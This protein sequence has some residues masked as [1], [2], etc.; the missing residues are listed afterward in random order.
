MRVRQV[1][2]KIRQS[3]KVFQYT[4]IKWVFKVMAGRQE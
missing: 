4:E 2:Q 3:E 1:M